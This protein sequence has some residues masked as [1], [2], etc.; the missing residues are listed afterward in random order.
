MAH[1]FL[2]VAFLIAPFFMSCVRCRTELVAMLAHTI[3]P[4]NVHHGHWR[5][6]KEQYHD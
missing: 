5:L 3:L 6:L 4:S 2:F 1:Y